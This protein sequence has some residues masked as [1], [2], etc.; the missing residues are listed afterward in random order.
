MLDTYEQETQCM[1]L[2]TFSGL[3]AGYGTKTIIDNISGNIESGRITA[4]IG[5]NGGGKSTLLRALGGLVDY[6]GSLELGTREVKNISRRD[7]G[8]TVGFLPQTINVK[9]A[10]SVYEIISLGRLPFR[11]I[12]EPMNNY[13]DKIV[14]E[15]AD[16]AEVGDLLFRTATELSGGERQRVLLAMILA[17]QPKLFLLDEPTSALD[18][19][20]ARCIF[21]LL[22]R[23]VSEG[24]SVV[25]AAHDLNS[26]I[27][28]C[29]DFIALKAGEVIAS[30][31]VSMLDGKIL[32]ELYGT[33]FQC[34]RSKEGNTAW[35]P[36]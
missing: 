18:P 11:G 21:S 22:R 19:N 28:F 33:K 9:T 29:D 3:C 4:L 12:L 32:H 30:G 36:E 14:L 2:Y 31:P 6:S 15:S 13:D 24:R 5:P 17:Q 10:F 34:Y 23:L 8:R 20:H 16:L 7:F 35:H 1:S 26:A 27:S 25:A